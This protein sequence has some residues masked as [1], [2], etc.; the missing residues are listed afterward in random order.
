[1]DNP[2]NQETRRPLATVAQGHRPIDPRATYD[3]QMFLADR[4]P[5]DLEYIKRHVTDPVVTHT[6]QGLVTQTKNLLTSSNPFYQPT[7]PFS[8]THPNYKN[9]AEPF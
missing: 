2:M 3:G 7:M 5:L 9:H 6:E 4:P 8:L 1:M